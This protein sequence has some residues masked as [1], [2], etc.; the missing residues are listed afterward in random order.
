MSITHPGEVIENKDDMARV[1]ILKQGSVAF[2]SK[3]NGSS[4][5][6][7]VID[8]IEVKKGENSIL[9]SLEFINPLS[10]KNYEL[11]SKEYSVLYTMD[12]ETLR[13]ILKEKDRD[14]EYFFYLKDK[15][16][17]IM[18]EFEIKKCE[19]CKS[20]HLKFR[21]PKLHYMPIRQ[22]IIYKNINS[23]KQKKNKRKE[24]PREKNLSKALNNHITE[25]KS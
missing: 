16:K 2:C 4:F 3:I 17:H 21:C 9:L 7:S 14:L 5:N 13:E 19:F 15:S 18:D 25:S 23:T 22:Q 10:V 12:I 20:K 6:N 11:Q 8:K 24:C 1:C